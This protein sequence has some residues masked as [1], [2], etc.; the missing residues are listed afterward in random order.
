L[1]KGVGEWERREEREKGRKGEGETLQK[2]KS[3]EKKTMA[4]AKQTDLPG[5]ENRMIPALQ[6]ALLEYAEIRDERMA[7]SAKE[8][9]LKGKVLG[10]MHQYKKT[11]YD[12]D[13]VHAEIIVESEKVK[14]TVPKKNGDGDGD[15][16]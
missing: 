6:E 1:R 2:P 15:G 8:V 4:R 11:E 9:E 12:Y 10:L 16:E 14:V 13:G 7:L 5:M 3:E